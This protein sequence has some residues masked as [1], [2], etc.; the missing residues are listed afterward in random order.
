[1]RRRDDNRMLVERE[2]LEQ[3]LNELVLQ[4]NLRLFL[5]GA[6]GE[7]PEIMWIEHIAVIAYE[8]PAKRATSVIKKFFKTVKTLLGKARIFN[9]FRSRKRRKERYN[10]G[11][12]R[13]ICRS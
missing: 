6:T 12:R 1:M 9:I 11:N 2:V 7:N 8:P 4:W 13:T 3:V 10:Y 5:D